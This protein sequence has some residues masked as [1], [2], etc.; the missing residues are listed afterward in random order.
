MDYSGKIIN[1]YDLKGLAKN[2]ILTER[3][4]LSTKS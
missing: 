3:T 2:F 1:I 4:F